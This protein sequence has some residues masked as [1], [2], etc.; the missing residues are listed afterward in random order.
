MNE[1]QPEKIEVKLAVVSEDT[2]KAFAIFGLSD[3]P[4][5]ERRIHFRHWKSGAL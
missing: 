5:E 4:K 1:I 2:A 3:Q